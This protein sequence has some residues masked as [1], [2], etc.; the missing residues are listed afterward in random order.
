MQAG[1][2]FVTAPASANFPGRHMQSPFWRQCLSGFGFLLGILGWQ[3]FAQATVYYVSN[4]GADANTGLSPTQAW[5]TLGKVSGVTLT[6]GDQ[7]LFN[8]GDTFYGAFNVWK[9][10][11]AGN[12]ITFG[13]Y[14][15]GANPVITGFTTVTDW[16]DLGSN[17]WE[18]T[19]TVSAL[20]T[21][22]MLSIDGVNTPLARYPRISDGN[23]GYLIYQSFSGNTSLTTNAL[24]GTPDWTG[25]EIVIRSSMYTMDRRTITAQSGGTITFNAAPSFDMAANWGFF[26]QNDSRLLTY[27]NAWYFNPGTGKVQIYSVGQPVNVKAASVGT[28]VN[29]LTNYITFQNLAFAGANQYFIN[30]PGN[31]NLTVQNCSFSYSGEAAI[32]GHVDYAKIYNCTFSEMNNAGISLGSNTSY[33]QVRNC[34]LTNIGVAPGMGLRGDYSGIETSN[35]TGL[36]LEY[37]TLTNVGFNPITVWG[38]G[39]LIKNNYINTFNLVLQDGGGIYVGRTAR[40]NGTEIRGNI[41]LNGIGNFYGTPWTDSQSIGIYVDVF[42]D[43]YRVYNNSVAFCGATGVQLAG[44]VSTDF[45]NNT[46]YGS[47]FGLLLAYGTIPNPTNT[48]IK[49]NIFVSTTTSNKTVCYQTNA[50]ATAAAPIAT[51]ADFDYNVYAKPLD[52][53]ITRPQWN[54]PIQTAGNTGATIWSVAQWQA[55]SGKDLHSTK[56]PQG[57]AALTDMQ[58]LYNETQ[59]V[60]TIPLPYDM[61]DMRG[62]RYWGSITLQPYTSAVLV[63]DAHPQS[64]TPTS[65]ASP[66]ATATVTVLTPTPTPTAP[67]FNLHGKVALA[68]PNPATGQVRFILNL[69]EPAEVQINLYN[70]AGRAVA[71]VSGNLPAGQGPGVVWHCGQAAPGIYLAQVRVDNQVRETLKIAIVGK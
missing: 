6:A 30:N 37:N 14:G 55:Y 50:Y 27:Q 28:L 41:V 4:V 35:H 9:S 71:Q 1:A 51:M 39:I 26:L 8:C 66:S 43:N 12:P 59:A 44:P 60:K 10:G 22:N 45:Q 36:L 54:E 49:N 42:C 11:A 3:P 53:Y 32:F 13:A 23:G 63:K 17:I 20:A 58:F 5:Q 62:N 68:F 47:K 25:A 24:T 19:N 46:V 56:S 61:L 70:A 18:S 33:G 52:D 65:T 64:P 31:T 69:P 16:T 21:C 2:R 48:T 15:T 34:T 29:C 38:D 67:A 57:I 40:P 7:V